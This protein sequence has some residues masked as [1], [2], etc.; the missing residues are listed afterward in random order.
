MIQKLPAQVVDQIAAGEVLERPANLVK[1]LIENSLDAGAT[2]LEIYVAQGGRSLLVKDNGSGIT[3]ED[4]PLAF[5][6]HATSKITKASDLWQLHSFG[7]R[8]EALASSAAVSQLTITTRTKESS[9]AFRQS[10]EFGTLGDI[11]PVGGDVGTTVEV[12]R[13]FENVP[14]RLKFLKTDSSEISQIKKTIKA[15]ALSNPLVT[16]RVYIEN[17]LLLHWP[18]TT[19]IKRIEDVL[20]KKDMLS[21]QNEGSSYAAQCFFTSP[22]DIEKTSQNMWFFVNKRWIQDRSLQAAIMEAYRNLLMHGEYPSAVVF[23]DVPTE[24]VDVNVS[25][26]KSQVKFSDPRAVFRLVH[27]GIRNEL[28][29]APWLKSVLTETLQPQLT[30]TGEVTI[31]NFA[32]QNYFP[33]SELERTQFQTKTFKQ[34]LESLAPYKT[35]A[36]TQTSERQIRTNEKPLEIKPLWSALQVLGQTNLTYIVAQSS[37]GVMFIDQHAAHERINFERLMKSWKTK[38]ML[39]SQSFLIPL[40]LK[41]ETSQIEALINYEPQLQKMGI[42]IEQGGPEMLYVL[43]CPAI[44]KE[45]AL[46][47]ALEKLAHEIQENG[48]SMAIEKKL[49]DIFATMAC[50]SSVRAGQSLSTEEMQSLL[51]QMDEFP[52]SSFCPHGRPVFVEYSFRELDT[53]FGR[54]V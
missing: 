25:P 34:T 15:L 21:G 18:A 17:Q 7:F 24:D 47:K 45:D 10:S 43:S 23:L 53:E 16:F 31:Q 1:E 44:L 5:E 52:L 50:H 22:S 35:E 28:E 12:A 46:A 2:E 54:I 39:E 30:P 13:L 6:R 9:S 27:Y 41:M 40:S 51:V 33:S 32:E 37:R 14:A 4:L 48:D 26:T 49:G 3:Q 11:H 38:S 42:S 36:V 20:I 29:K 8:G 19:W